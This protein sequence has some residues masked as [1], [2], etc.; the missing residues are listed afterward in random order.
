[1]RRHAVRPVSAAARLTLLIGASVALASCGASTPGAHARSPVAAH[2]R[3]PA[4]GSEAAA[5]TRGPNDQR[6]GAVTGSSSSSSSSSSSPTTASGA[7]L[8]PLDKPA[9]LAPFRRSSAPGEGV[10][11]PA[12]RRVE[13][14]PAVYLTT[15][16]PRAASEPAGVAWMDTKLLSARLY[17]G[18]KSP[19]GG[20]YRYTAPI[21]PRSA[22]TLVAAFNGGFMMSAAEGGYYT[23]GRMI[24]PLRD[25]SA[26]LVIYADGSVNVGEWGTDVTMT[27]Q[28]VAVRQNLVL[29]VA[30][31]RPTP[32]AASSDWQAWG[33]TCGASSCEP[34]V[35]GVEQQWRSAVGVT[36]DGA[37]IYVQAP[38]IDPLQ[39]AQLLVRAGV[40]RGME[41][42]INPDWPI[43]AT[44]RPEGEHGLASASNGHKLLEGTVQGPSIF[45][46]AWW[47]RDF[48]TMSARHGSNG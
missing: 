30:D 46:E 13:G 37:L 32:R 19:G 15:L 38:A 20:P 24:D 4:G 11:R 3:S 34:S 29:L 48:V 1:M 17:S 28:V 7:Q 33:D 22:R 27:P 42:D 44:Y 21:R 2:V 31:G 14:T 43:F 12:G 35:P 47:A 18:S 45:F 8:T 40:L 10:W 9:N 26:S 36:G 25:G 41:L 23:E 6:P 5:R 16:T 39:L